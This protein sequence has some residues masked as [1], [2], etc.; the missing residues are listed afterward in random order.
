MSEEPTGLGATNVRLTFRTFR[1][2]VRKLKVIAEAH[3]LR[4]GRHLSLGAA[5]N[6]IISKYDASEEEAKVAR[7]KGT[8]R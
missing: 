8:K 3:D 7:K 2:Y 1:T 6:L 4:L 5:L